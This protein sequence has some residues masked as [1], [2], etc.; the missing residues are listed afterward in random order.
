[1]ADYQLR[2]YKFG[3]MQFGFL[4]SGVDPISG[5]LCPDYLTQW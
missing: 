5:T 3:N 4:L 1:M 2:G